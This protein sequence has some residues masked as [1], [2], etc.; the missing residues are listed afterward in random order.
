MRRFFE[1]VVRPLLDIVSPRRIVEIGAAEGINSGLVASWCEGRGSRLDV[2]D[3]A[4]RFEV[5]MFENDYP[6]AKVHVGRSVDILAQLPVADVVLIDGDHNWYTVYNE[7]RI[8]GAASA[9]AGKPMPVCVLHDT[10]WPYGRRDLYYDPFTV[11]ES[12]RLPYRRGP[13][14]PDLSPLVEFGLNPHLCHAEAEGGSHNGVQTA[15]EDFA[16]EREG[17]FRITYL[18]VLFGLT[19]IVPVLTALRPALSGFLDRLELNSHWGPLVVIAENERCHG[20]AAMHRLAALPLPPHLSTAR[21]VNGRSFSPNIP[22]EVLS[23]VQ[24]GVL[25]QKYRGRALLKSPFDLSLYTQLIERLRPRTIIEI[26]TFQ[27]GSAIWFADMLSI[28]GIEG[29]VVTVDLQSPTLEDRRITALAGSATALEFV[30]SNTLLSSLAR[31]W[32]VVEDSAHNKETCLSVLEF[33]DRKLT[34]GDYIVI[35]AGVVRG[36]PGE[37]YQSYQDGPSRAIESFLLRRGED[38][39]IDSELCDFFGYN[40][41][42]NPNGWLRRR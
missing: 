18:P 8:L 31:P 42:Y 26:G 17:Q 40:A 12:D 7:L 38:Y 25:R 2:I 30:L 4:P 10:G 14:M 32:L 29:R 20:M 3:T 6:A 41:T 5:D 15:V 16:R 23:A 36:L 34:P 33:F 9:A 39:D 11:P 27:G 21:P 35:E 24:S 28:Q 37:R 13:V 1:S 22:A 19:L